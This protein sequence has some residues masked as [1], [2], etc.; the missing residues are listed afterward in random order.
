MWW[1]TPIIPATLEAEAKSS[2]E[3]GRQRLWWAKIMPLHSS[4]GDRVTLSQK[5]TNKKNQK[6][7]FCV[8]CST[9]TSN[10][11]WMFLIVNA[12]DQKCLDF[13][14]LLF[15]CFWDRVT[16]SPRLECSG[17]ISAHCNLHLL[18]WS[19]SPGSATWVAGITGISYYARLIFVFLVEIG[20]HHIGQAGLNSWAQV[21]THLSLP[22]CWDYRGEP[23]CVA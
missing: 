2:L 3:P 11:G 15:V 12:R 13:W 9:N 20:F 17:I 7:V 16:L 8:F 18:G 1:H 23:P 6:T 4:L 21:I 14:F 5:Q 19:S 10:T 22:K